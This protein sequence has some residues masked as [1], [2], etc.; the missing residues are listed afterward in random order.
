[1]STP[2][3]MK[4]SPMQRNFGTSPA[5]QTTDR[6]KRIARNT[7]FNAH[8]R[9]TGILPT[10]KNTEE[11]AKWYSNKT[12]VNMLNKKQAEYFANKK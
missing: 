1:M 12:N 5:K 7:E 3:K 6:E 4:G 2:F 8:A 10:F 9:K 11:K